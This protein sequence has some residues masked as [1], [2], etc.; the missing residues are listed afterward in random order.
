M[1]RTATCCRTHDPGVAMSAARE[2]L[3]G[4]GA[5]LFVVV[6]T[7]VVGTTRAAVAAP[8]GC[9]Q[10]AAGDAA[11]PR[12]DVV[13]LCATYD[14]G[15]LALSLAP[16]QPTDPNA[17]P[18][19]EG[20]TEVRWELDLT[21]DAAA[22]LVAVYGR[23]SGTVQAGVLD[24]AGNLR[25]TG[26]QGFDGATYTAQFAATCL[27][28]PPPPAVGIAGT[29]TFD[30]DASD[31][32]LDEVVDR[33]PDTGVA[34]PYGPDAPSPPATEPSPA[35]EPSPEPPPSPSCAPVAPAAAGERRVDRVAGT[36]RIG[37]AIALSSDT[38]P[39]CA[40]VV[41]L[42]RADQYPDALAGAPLAVAL[43]GPLLLTGPDGLD[44]DA[45]AEIERLGPSS[46]VLL[47][48]E[49]ALDPAV[50]QEVAALGVD[51]VSRLAGGNRFA[52]A[53]R[54]ATAVGGTTAVVVEGVDDD[55]ERGWPDAVSASAYA[56]ARGLPI[57]LT[58]TDVLPD[59]TVR[60]LD[61]LGT[62]DVL[63][64][65]GPAAVGADVTDGLTAGGRAV[66][67]LAGATRY[68]TAV[69]VAD[70]AV[71]AGGDPART[72][73]ATGLDYPDALTAGAAAGALDAPL[74]LVDG[75]DAAAS[76]DTLDWI[77]TYGDAWVRA[78]LVGGTE[79]ISAAV[80]ADVEGRG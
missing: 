62:T 8:S 58:D 73:F 65:G 26:T 51:G 79:A 32:D 31:P 46:V 23:Y 33:S 38:W 17:D 67:R 5:V 27:G 47:G 75:R 39:T 76:P 1:P 60:G 18:A 16:V 34:G 53:A 74:V 42:A 24:A 20:A 6:A 22:D 66:T 50:A 37:T 25:C 36:S 52:T 2:R 12:A 80:A 69:A 64:V 21:G 29:M 61:D 57:L 43:G 4:V 59:D 68:A 44:A 54:I 55:P 49:E 19:W 15:T 3:I 48:G 10:E 45:A 30:A 13:G 14:G 78:T 9:T 11:D 63:V 40:D 72:Y 77:G 70:A 41:V 71:A 56:A 35:P 28:T 7:A